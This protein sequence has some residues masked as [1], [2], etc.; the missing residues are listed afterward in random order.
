[1]KNEKNEKKA[2]VLKNNQQRFSGFKEALEFIRRMDR[3]EERSSK[4]SIF[5]G[6]NRS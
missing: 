1:M 5:V 2:D 4:T 3:W 6:K